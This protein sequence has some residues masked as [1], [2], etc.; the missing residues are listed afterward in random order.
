MCT[1]LK[2]SIIIKFKRLFNTTFSI[3][4]IS[5]TTK[6]FAFIPKKQ[7]K[8]KNFITTFFFQNMKK[9]TSWFLKISYFLL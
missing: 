5:S 7:Q 8:K 3:I 4:N 1:E 2:I 9:E 6:Y